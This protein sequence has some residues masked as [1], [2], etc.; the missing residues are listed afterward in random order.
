MPYTLRHF[1]GP[2]LLRLPV[3]AD[4]PELVIPVA[5]PGTVVGVVTDAN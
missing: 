3:V 1:L 4:V 5:A 2:R